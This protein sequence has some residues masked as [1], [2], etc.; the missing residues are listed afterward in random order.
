M[1]LDLVPLFIASG[2]PVAVETSIRG[3]FRTKEV[4]VN[5]ATVK[6]VLMQFNVS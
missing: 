1:Y 3:E 5:A 2:G 4:K 6:G